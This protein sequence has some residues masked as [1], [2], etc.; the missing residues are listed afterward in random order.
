MLKLGGI[1]SYAWIFNCV[2]LGMGQLGDWGVS[3][4]LTPLLF[5]VNCVVKKKH[6]TIEVP[7]SALQIPTS[8]GKLLSY[9]LEDFPVEPDPIHLYSY[10]LST[11][12]LKKVVNDYDRE[13]R[14]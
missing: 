2:G 9:F 1:K 4:L 14:T 8:R 5:K 7:P 3:S 10:S 12:L 13:Q 6:E 11:F